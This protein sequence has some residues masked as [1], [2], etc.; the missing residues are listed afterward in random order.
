M[1]GL[2]GTLEFALKCFYRDGLALFGLKYHVHKRTNILQAFI[3]HWCLTNGGKA[4]CCCGKEEERD[5]RDD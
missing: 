5:A 2:G 4:G 1:K 3:S